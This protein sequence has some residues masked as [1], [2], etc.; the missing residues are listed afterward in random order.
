MQLQGRVGN[1]G[2]H[3]DYLVGN[4]SL[5]LDYKRYNVRFCGRPSS[6]EAHGEGEF[7]VHR[8]HY[9]EIAWSAKCT[10]SG[11]RVYFLPG[12]P[13]PRHTISGLIDTVNLGAV[14]CKMEGI[15]TYLGR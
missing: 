14:I 7:S 8:N 11:N 13:L 4:D 10:L 15:L 3:V 6:E 2:E 1:D 12:L 9:A 5:W